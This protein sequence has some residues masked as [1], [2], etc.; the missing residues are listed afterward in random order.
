[1][2]KGNCYP[3]ESMYFHDR[4]THARI[5]QVTN[6]P[7]I[8]HHPFFMIPAYGED[9][10]ALFFISHRTGSP[11]I[12]AEQ[13]SMGKLLQLTD[14]DDLAEWSIHP[15]FNGSH[16]YFTA[17]TGC[18]R[19]DTATLEE[20]ML[21]DLGQV[22]MREGGM[23]AAGMGTTALSRDN[24]W[25]AVRY[26]EGGLACLAVIDTVT[27]YMDTIL[28]RDEISHMQ[29]CP[30]D[31]NLLFY[32]GPLHDRVWVIHRDGSGNRRLYERD[33]AN[34][35]WITHETWIP[36]T[37]ELAFVDWQRGI[38][39][40]HADTREVRQVTTFNA[41]HA[42][43]NREGT[44]MVADTNF[45]DIGLQLFDPLDRIGAPSLL[46]YPDATNRGDHWGGPFPYDNGPIPVYA[47]Q[48]THPHPSFS[49]DGHFIVYTSDASGYAQVYEIDLRGC[50]HSL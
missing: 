11:Q 30:D 44:L 7:S 23:I 31:A 20:E 16:V 40:V 15:S 4:R 49:A 37:H 45:H 9:M 39:S 14:R 21:V 35:E 34:K 19:I 38:R 32:A 5:R 1:M 33:A 17:G 48:H 29:F 2:G 12:F 26:T 41:W 42:V 36:G 10:K 13:R 43:C 46:C 6:H 27:G 25:W 8:H 3:S 18:W 22:Q 24:R 50:A 28:R 47:P